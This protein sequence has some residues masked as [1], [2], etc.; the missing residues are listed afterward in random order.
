MKCKHQSGAGYETPERGV[1]K[2]SPEQEQQEQQKE[3]EKKRQVECGRKHDEFGN[4]L[5]IITKQALTAEVNENA[6]RNQN[7]NMETKNERG[8][9][10]EMETNEQNKQGESRKVYNFAFS[11]D[12]KALEW[13]EMQA[14]EWCRI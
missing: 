6:S 2:E 1:E 12:S 4:V 14:P 10:I 11:Y 7:E 5:L 3:R 8:D 9:R 13:Y